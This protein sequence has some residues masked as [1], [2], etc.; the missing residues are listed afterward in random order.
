MSAWN[1]LEEEL[2]V[3]AAK[4]GRRRLDEQWLNRLHCTGYPDVRHP[5]PPPELHVAVAQFN[6]GQYWLCHE[7][8]E[9]LWLVEGYPLRL[10]YHG[11]IKSA[12]G[13]L[14][15]ERRNHLGAK[16]KLRD[17]E[18]NLTPFSPRFMGL[19]IGLLRGD[20]GERLAL[21]Q[22]GAAVDWD[23]VTRLAPP[24]LRPA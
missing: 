19:Q 20:M 2:P 16:L 5:E 1:Q 13:L 6:C 24:L 4:S 21:L 18:Y 3:F 11:L 15:L 7:T 12:V 10:F 23:R 9:G 14:H 22:G 17:A 8:L